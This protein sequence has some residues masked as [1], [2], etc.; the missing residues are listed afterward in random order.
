MELWILTV[1]A[2]LGIVGLY[3][4]ISLTIARGLGQGL[5]R[6]NPIALATAGIFATCAVGHGLHAMHVVPPWSAIDPFTAAAGLAMFSDWRLAAWDAL[7]AIVAVWY[8]ILRSRFAIVYRGASLCED[9][10]SRQRQAEQLRVLLVAG[11]ADAET[12]FRE[13]RR[14]DG[15]R[16]LDATLEQGKTIITTLIGEGR[17]RP[18]PGELTRS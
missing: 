5:W 13:G 12:D 16:R 7:T 1:A 18:H 8:W 11:L 4:A 3:A 9:M 17:R 6:S 15:L 2:N 14:E 10:A